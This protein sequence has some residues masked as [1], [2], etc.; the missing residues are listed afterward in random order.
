M[1][2]AINELAKAREVL[3]TERERLRAAVDG[4]VETNIYSFA[5]FQVQLDRVRVLTITVR[6]LA[7]ECEAA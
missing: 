4:L 1:S 5:E 2:E 7:R 6:R 3:A